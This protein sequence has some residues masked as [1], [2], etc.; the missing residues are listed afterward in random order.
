MTMGVIVDMI[1]FPSN[2]PVEG[3]LDRGLGERIGAEGGGML[4]WG[5]CRRVGGGR[6]ETGGGGVWY[7]EYNNIVFCVVCVIL[8][9]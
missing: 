5:L 6:R 7:V 8:F 9:F 3:Q 4:N 2:D 1:R